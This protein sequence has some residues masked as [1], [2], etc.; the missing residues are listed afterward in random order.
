MPPIAGTLGF[1]DQPP[2]LRTPSWP[3]RLGA[4][5][6]VS[7]SRRS[8]GLLSEV[9]EVLCRTL[10]LRVVEIPPEVHEPFYG[11]SAD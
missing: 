1:V 8:R 7:R 3:A 6:S 9:E 2:R 5:C 4:W 11:V 10:D